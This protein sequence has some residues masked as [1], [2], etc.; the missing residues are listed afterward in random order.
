MD[1]VVID[2]NGAALS[3]RARDPSIVSTISLMAG[4]RQP[5]NGTIL[6]WRGSPVKGRSRQATTMTLPGARETFRWS[7]RATLIDMESLRLRLIPLEAAADT[8]TLS[9]Q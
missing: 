6:Q 3:Q 9:P 7:R 5:G 1:Q 4:T 8:P 2:R